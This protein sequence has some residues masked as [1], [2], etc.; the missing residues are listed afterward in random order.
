MREKTQYARRGQPRQL[1]PGALRIPVTPTML[2]L[3]TAGDRAQRLR[4]RIHFFAV[5]LP[6]ACSID[7]FTRSAMNVA[8]G[9][10][11]IWT[12]ALSSAFI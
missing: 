6:A 5:D 12:L 11:L 8:N 4:G 10:M 2:R 1:L 3:R 9:S 7:H